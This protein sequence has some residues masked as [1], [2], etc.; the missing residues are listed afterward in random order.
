[1]T[2]VTILTKPDCPLCDQAKTALET[3]ADE[4]QLTVDLVSLDSP[5]GQGLAAG[6]GLVFPPAVFL[7]GQ[8]FS[9]GR[10]SERKLRRAL[11]AATSSNT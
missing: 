11:Q 6:S 9:H 4:Y 1:M 2:R 8:P 5:K 3:L 7:D 10:L